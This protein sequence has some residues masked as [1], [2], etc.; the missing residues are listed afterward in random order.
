MT[1]FP[2]RE[3]I[4]YISSTFTKGTLSPTYKNCKTISLLFGGSLLGRLFG[5]GFLG[6]GGLGLGSG[7]LGLDRTLGGR[8]GLFG[9]RLLGSRGFFGDGCLFGCRLLW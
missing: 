9:C 8:L 3:L 4:I 7:F 1:I 6:G 5:S 2:S